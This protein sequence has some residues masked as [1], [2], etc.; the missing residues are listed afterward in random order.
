MTY[1]IVHIR[2]QTDF[3]TR[4]K[5]L[6][7]G[8]CTE[9]DTGEMNLFDA[10]LVSVIT[11]EEGL[12]LNEPNQ[13]L[14]HLTI[15][16]L[17]VTGDTVRTYA[18]GLVVWL[19]FLKLKK[20]D[21]R[22]ASEEL[23]ATFRNYLASKH[24][25]NGLR[26]YAATTVNNRT[27]I[28]EMF[29]VWA[30][31]RNI[32]SS[33]LGKYL[34][35]R[36]MQS[37]ERQWR[38]VDR[39]RKST[40]SLRMNVIQR[41]PRILSFEEISRLFQVARQPYKLMFRWGLASGMRRFEVC[42]LRKSM[43]PSVEKIAVQ[44]MTLVAIDVLR[45]GGKLASVYVP[46]EL[47]EETHWY[48]LMERPVESSEEYSDLIFLNQKGKPFL[49]GSISRE[50]RRCADIVGTDATL[51][52]LRHTFATLVLGMLESRGSDERPLNSIKVVQLLLGHANV[53]TTETYLRALEVASDEVKDALDFLYGASL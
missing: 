37:S 1:K 26:K 19:E 23:L 50:F 53:T 9:E 25:D 14:A 4:S 21:F 18:E 29:Y 24:E 7:L 32:F 34:L 45:K 3:G 17:S 46:A 43:L 12:P 38:G 28:A 30:E 39:R 8:S 20:T 16:S 22:E 42:N 33:E 6:E 51:H 40:D 31:R 15:R 47:A 52:H 49:R 2:P 5:L 10:T 44:G 27:V 41:M 13:F 11:D 35:L 36:N 48:C